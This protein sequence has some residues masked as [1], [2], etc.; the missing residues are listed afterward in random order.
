MT[1]KEYDNYLDLLTKKLE[2][3]NMQTL[4]TMKKSNENII[5]EP[6]SYLGEQ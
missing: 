5:K 3:I 6:F 1:K 2:E 4:K